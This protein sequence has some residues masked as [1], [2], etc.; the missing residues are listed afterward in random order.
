MTDLDYNGHRIA[1]RGH[2]MSSLTLFTRQC[3][4]RTLN[5]LI[6]PPVP[7]SLMMC[8]NYFVVLFNCSGEKVSCTYWIHL[9]CRS[10]SS[11]STMKSASTGFYETVCLETYGTSDVLLPS[12]IQVCAANSETVQTM[13][14]DTHTTPTHTS[15]H[16]QTHA[17]PIHI[18]RT[19]KHTHT[20]HM[21]TCVQ[22]Y[23]HPHTH[24]KCLLVTCRRLVVFC[25]CSGFLHQWNSHFTIIIIIIIIIHIIIIIT[26]SLWPWI[27]LRRYKPQ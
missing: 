25:G 21:Y 14:L 26:A 23:K 18:T 9:T 22:T 4:Y 10:L 3:W 7:T 13:F 20:H 17:H 6:L 16:T 2:N 24:T 1:C 8:N 11:T 27:L 19:F 12:A 5:S 15:T